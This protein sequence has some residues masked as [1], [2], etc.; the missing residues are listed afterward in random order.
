MS[1]MN[2]PRTPAEAVEAVIGL[3]FGGVASRLAKHFDVSDQTVVWWR[4]GERDGRPVRFPAE[5]CPSCE[6]LT[7]GRVRCEELRPDVAWDVLR[8]QA[9]ESDTAAATGT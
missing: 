6:R 7:S 3:A 9:G 2:K 1:G 5:L 8:L 4:K